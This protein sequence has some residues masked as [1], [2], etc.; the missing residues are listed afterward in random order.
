MMDDTEMHHILGIS[1]KRSEEISKEV[2]AALVETGKIDEGTMG[3]RQDL[4]DSWYKLSS[5]ARRHN[6]AGA[7]FNEL[8]ENYYG[9]EWHQLQE[10]KDN[11][12]IIDMMDYGTD[13]LTFSEFDELVKNALKEQ[14]GRT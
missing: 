8:A 10:L 5:L 13:S 2:T 14:R 9:V 3:D 6:T 11:D 12:R 7:E 4:I 1:D